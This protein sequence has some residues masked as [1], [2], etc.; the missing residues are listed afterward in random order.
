MQKQIFLVLFTLSTFQLFSQA[1]PSDTNTEY[2]SNNKIIIKK[3]LSEYAGTPYENENFVK[4]IVYKNNEYVTNNPLFR[5]NAFRDEIEVKEYAAQEEENAKVLIK[6]KEISVKM[7]N[8]FFVYI[9]KTSNLENQGYFLQLEDGEKFNLFKKIKKQYVEGM[10]APTSMKRDVP[11]SFKIEETYYL[12]D[13]QK[14]EY[15]EL[16][17][18]KS[19]IVKILKKYKENIAVY[20]KEKDLNLKNDLDLS[21]LI[22]HLNT[23]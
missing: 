14:Q 8:K 21:K 20:S 23:L 4:G 18:R 22:H 7:G 15:I 12:Y 6:S 16:P 2:L 9:P 19:K 11:P 5:Y 1:Q 17:N 13:K 10:A 3:N